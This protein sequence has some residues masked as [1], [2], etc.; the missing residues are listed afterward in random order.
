MRVWVVM[1]AY[2]AAATLEQTLDDL[3]M[4]GVERVLLV[5][6]ASTDGTADL[7]RSLGLD[8]IEHTTNRGY[9]G[10]QKSC[11]NAALE[12][13]A[14]IIVMVHPDYQY[15]S[16]IVPVMVEIIRLGICDV[17]LGNRIRTRRETLDGGM[18]VWKY[19]TNRT[20]TA[21]ENFVLG[22]S[23][24]D[25]HSGFRAYSR[26]ALER[27]PY[28]LNSEDF[29]FDQELLIQAANLGLKL[30][31]VPVPVRYFPEASSINV[32]RSLRY[33]SD[34]LLAMAS[35]FTHRAGLRNDPRF[36]DTGGLPS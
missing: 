5:D 8:V 23:L 29:S 28:E 3:P 15:D 1:P 13:G 34:T 24:G 2:N 25:F 35:L 7:A 21:F 11:Y 12:G 19:F 6:D 10:N 36:R 14:D 18:P 30:G 31:D 32:R 33:G 22:Q 27:I 16:R 4:D 26:E 20:S 9:G 17:V